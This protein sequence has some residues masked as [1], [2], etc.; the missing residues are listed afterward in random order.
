MPLF[1]LF[2]TQFENEQ[3]RN[4]RDVVTG[5]KRSDESTAANVATQQ[6]VGQ[7]RKQAFAQ[8]YA[9][10]GSPAMAQRTAQGAATD[11]TM[12]GGAMMAQQRAGDVAGAKANLQSWNDQQLSGIHNLV[13]IGA[14]ALQM[15]GSGGSSDDAAAKQGPG[16]S[17]SSLSHPTW[18]QADQTEGNNPTQQVQRPQQSAQQ[19]QQFAQQP[20][21]PPQT[22]TAQDVGSL[23]SGL[24]APRQTA[25]TPGGMQAIQAAT[26]PWATDLGGPM[27][28]DQIWKQK[29]NML[30]SDERM[31][32]EAQNG[33]PDA[34]AFLDALTAHM[35]Q[36]RQDLPADLQRNADKAIREVG[37]RHSGFQPGQYSDPNPEKD[38]LDDVEPQTYEYTPEGQ[39]AGGAPGRQLGIM[40]QDV[41]QVA[42]PDPEGNLR[43]DPQRALSA[44]L[45]GQANLNQRLNALEGSG[46]PLEGVVDTKATPT[47]SPPPA[48]AVAP[49]RPRVDLYNRPGNQRD[50]AADLPR[51]TRRGPPSA[52]ERRY[53][54][55]HAFLAALRGQFRGGA[56]GDEMTKRDNTPQGNVTYS[57]GKFGR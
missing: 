47:P 1:G 36:L 21:Q 53:Q 11:A 50:P 56:V 30:L 12:Q 19:P 16:L 6:A 40:A 33:N 34:R 49:P 7:A 13:G 14:Q 9:N 57:R 18:Q 42:S 55:N 54:E 29:Q 20:Q 28:P 17:M 3:H 24:N 48:P 4:D 26:Q 2:P 51:R 35:A 37:G 22:S 41:P 38:F 39:A 25:P 23:I 52:E 45:A 46:D 32:Q 31:K 43:I 44:S 8:A 15:A 27:S 10:R 5:R